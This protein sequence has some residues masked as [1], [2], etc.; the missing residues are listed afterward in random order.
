MPTSRCAFVLLLLTIHSL[1]ASAT[2]FSGDSGH[3]GELD[4]IARELG[5]D[6]ERAKQLF[7]EQ[8][9]REAAQ[10]ASGTPKRTGT[11]SG[12]VEA[13]SPIFWPNQ[14][15]LLPLEVEET[16]EML[17]GF[18][19]RRMVFSH[20]EMSFQMRGLEGVHYLSNVTNVSAVF[21]SSLF[22]ENQIQFHL[23]AGGGWLPE[24]S[25]YYLSAYAKGLAEQNKE[26]ITFLQNPPWMQRYAFQ[27]NGQNWGKVSYSLEEEGQG[28]VAYVEF[29]L[30]MAHRLMVVR[31]QGSRHWVQGRSADM[32]RTLSGLQILE[33]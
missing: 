23:F 27:L 10:P 28:S 4:R 11:S 31:I 17:D 16:V 20:P 6:P 30:P 9:E 18:P 1:N 15:S 13:D 12:I 14:P 2:N 29:F 25:E 33:K 7:Q 26:R 3:Q 5:G 32:E 8:L 24:V 22:P 21:A 19:E